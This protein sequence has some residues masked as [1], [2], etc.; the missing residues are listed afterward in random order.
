M[1]HFVYSKTEKGRTFTLAVWENKGKNQRLEHVGTTEATPYAMTYGEQGEA[2]QLILEKQPRLKN[3][4]LKKGLR[5][6]PRYFHLTEK[7]GFLLYEV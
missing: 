5:F 1:K 7:E 4:I 2:W 3:M 6:D